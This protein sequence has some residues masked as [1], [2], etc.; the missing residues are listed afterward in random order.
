MISFWILEGSKLSK[1]PGRFGKFKQ[2]PLL[3]AGNIQQN[4]EWKI[5]VGTSTGDLYVFESRDVVSG[6]EK[7][8]SGAILTI[9][10]GRKD[11]PFFVTGG[12]DKMIKVWNQTL[13][14]ISS[15]NIA[16]FSIL[17]GSIASLDIKPGCVSQGNPL[18]LLV[19]TSG[20]EIVEVCA[21][22][23]NQASKSLNTFDISSASAT[24][25]VYSH[26]SGELWGLAPHP[27]NPDIVVTVGDDS[28]LRI[29]SI[30]KNAMVSHQLLE[31]PARCV[32]WHPTG[33]CVA[34]GFHEA[35]SASGRK[36]ATKSKTKATTSVRSGV[37]L[38][39][40]NPTTFVCSKICEG[41]S[42]LAWIQ[43]IK[44]S[45]NGLFLAACS[46]DKNMYVFSI[47]DNDDF[48]TWRDC[49]SAPKYTFSKHSSAVLHVDFSSDCKYFMTNCQ[50]G[51]LLFGH[52][53][54]GVQETSAS[55]LADYNN[56]PGNDDCDD[57][58]SS[59]QG[60]WFTQTCKLGWPVQGIF[61]PGSD[62][63]DINAVDRDIS[64]KYLATSDDFGEVKIYRFPCI[65]DKA[66][67]I[68]ARGHSS[69]VTN[70]RWTA[71]NMLISVGGNDK[72]VFIWD[73]E[74]K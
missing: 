63:S 72:C 17:D 49:L 24:V 12:K 16:P 34:V 18:T 56:L 36:K 69:H 62:L 74:E 71:S 67:A 65:F 61:P 46:H 3:C 22:S 32:A 64:W 53:E 42:S 19:G 48:D 50:A 31:W 44:F 52:L 45:P 10:E 9:A 58:G 21:S 27:T 73:V 43:E 5:V 11:G 59:E 29:W 13:Q 54:S 33:T 70:V 35:V 30:S 41:C 2:S 25:L 38:F 37:K 14:A 39:A 68:I 15:F 1:K 66:K 47:P 40:V 23:E 4:N 51:E 26:F 28:V 60:F 8:H 7:A 57:N 6:V 20:G 55:K